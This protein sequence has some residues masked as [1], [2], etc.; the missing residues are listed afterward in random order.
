MHIHTSMRAGDV[1]LGWAACVYFCPGQPSDPYG[2]LS[3]S[4]IL[5]IR[6]VLQVRGGHRSFTC[7]QP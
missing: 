4:V 6:V 1:A 5:Q 3:P 7:V 2:R